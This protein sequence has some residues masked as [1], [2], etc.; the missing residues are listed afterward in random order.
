MINR[1]ATFSLITLMSASLSSFAD[2]VGSHPDMN[3]RAAEFQVAGQVE[4]ITDKLYSRSFE[5][6][7]Q[8]D[9]SRD[10]DAQQACQTNNT[11]LIT[12]YSENGMAHSEI[13]VRLDGS[14]IGRLS[15]YYPDGAPG[16]KTPSARGIITLEIPAG[17]HTLDADSPNLSWPSQGFTVQKCEC[18]LLPLT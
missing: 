9:Q 17:R 15:S 10:I 12:V 2:G 18:L 16:C 7:H 3:N 6:F 4:S 11:A 8:P 13:D 5:K 1:T 14:P